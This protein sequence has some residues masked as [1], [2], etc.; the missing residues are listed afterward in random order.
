M[1]Y[2]LLRG[3]QEELLALQELL[4]EDLINNVV[5]IIE[6]IAL[7]STLVNTLELFRS[8]NKR[9]FV[10]R[11]PTVGTFEDDLSSLEN[12]NSEE[13]DESEQKKYARQLEYKRKYLEM[14]QD[15]SISPAVFR[16][17]D[18]DAVYEQVQTEGRS[19]VAVLFAN[20][21]EL[22]G[23]TIPAGDNIL[24]VPEFGLN[25]DINSELIIFRDKF[26]KRS[27]NSQYAQ[28]P[29]E[30]FSRDQLLF[31]R[32]N[33]GG[34]SD[35]SIIGKAYDDS[36]FAPYAIAIHIVYP[37]EGTNAFRVRHFVSDSN[38]S[39][40]DPA[41]K[42]FEAVNKL[43]MWSEENP[44]YITLGITRFKRQVENHNY[45]GLGCIKRYSLM[46]HLEIADRMLA[47]S[48]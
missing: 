15:Q 43:L 42:F 33:Y 5:P 11:N 30:F 1:Y 26:N 45:P 48:I 46:H 28:E 41:R 38:L 21:E 24:F 6:P 29:D 2:P 12:T 34:F 7:S 44:Q 9:I 31:A 17:N 10:A 14:I 40:R 37:E 4:K 32:N 27:S 3:K 23:E 20:E 13:M 47:G 16:G 25:S 18:F 19:N 35:Y 36:G 22:L 39:N 8:K